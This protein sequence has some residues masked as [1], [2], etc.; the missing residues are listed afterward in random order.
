MSQPKFTPGPWFLS[1]DSKSNVRTHPKHTG[2]TLAIINGMPGTKTASQ[3]RALANAHLIAAAP[4][5]YAALEVLITAPEQAV[6]AASAGDVERYESAKKAIQD[7]R[8]MAKRALAKARGEEAH[9]A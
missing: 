1:P 2:T 6:E 9:H 7:A 3:R 5:L 8:L 4:D